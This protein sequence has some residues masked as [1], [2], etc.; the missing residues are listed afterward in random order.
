MI[1]ELEAAL[2]PARRDRQRYNRLRAEVS[3]AAGDDLGP[4]TKHRAGIG[5]AA[6]E[7]GERAAADDGVDPGAAGA[8]GLRSKRGNRRSAARP[9]YGCC[10]PT[11]N[12]RPKV[13][14]EA[15]T[16]CWPP[17]LAVAPR[18]V[19]AINSA[20]SGLAVMLLAMPP[21]T[22]NSVALLVVP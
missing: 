21:A 15:E 1:A 10:A 18:S 14:A 7:H 4:A 8:D 20:P 17:S 19:R 9:S 5:H 6:G 16:T 12:C 11:Q 2:V 13:L 3:A 22:T